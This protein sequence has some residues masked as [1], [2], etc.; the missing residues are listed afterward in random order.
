MR[1]I[2]VRNVDSF[3]NLIQS[4]PSK[5]NKKTVESILFNVQKKGD[6]AIRKYE[7]KFSG[8]SVSS[9]RVSNKEIQNAYSQVSKN[10]LA[11]IKK[12]QSLL[13]KSEITV[14]NQLKHIQIK[15]AGTKILKSFVAI[16]S[17]GCY[18]PGGLAR[19]PS[20]A[21]MSI[22]PAKVAGVKKII[23]VSPPNKNGKIEDK[24]LEFMGLLMKRSSLA[25]GKTEFRPFIC[26]KM[27]GFA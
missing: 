11:A 20:S 23:V 13:K 26:W 15:S 21:I 7:K 10:Q 24:G 14:K 3:T 27:A 1:I 19:Y 6:N 12:V 8:I 18:V 17:V 5:K 9:L 4:K 22:V 2:F 16:D 25:R